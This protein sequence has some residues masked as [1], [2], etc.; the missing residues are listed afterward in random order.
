[1]PGVREARRAEG[2]AAGPTVAACAAC[3]RA[4]AL[5]H[6]WLQPVRDEKLRV[7]MQT[8]PAHD[9]ASFVSRRHE[10]R[11]SASSE[12]LQSATAT[13]VTGFAGVRLDPATLVADDEAGTGARAASAATDSYVV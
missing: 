9:S 7:Q 8:G 1:M 3:A 12:R 10:R 4:Q 2:A 5:E 11:Q 13:A 6:N